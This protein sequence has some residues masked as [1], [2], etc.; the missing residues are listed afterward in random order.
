MVPEKTGVVRIRYNGIN[1]RWEL[2]RDGDASLAGSFGSKEEAV[3]AG[4]QLARACMPCW[5]VGYNEDGVVTLEWSY[6][7]MSSSPSTAASLP[8]A[9]PR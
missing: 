7:L 5:L 6:G 3:I 9:T 8:Q 2:V 1:A 4:Q